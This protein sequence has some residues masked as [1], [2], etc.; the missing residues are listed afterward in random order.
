MQLCELY[1]NLTDFGRPN[2]NT[3]L[4]KFENCLHRPNYEGNV[5]TNS[6]FSF[7]PTNM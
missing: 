5:E 7:T 3:P 2:A 6:D 4:R 1:P